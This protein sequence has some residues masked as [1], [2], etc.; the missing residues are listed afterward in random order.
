MGAFLRRPLAR[1]NS[2]D[3]LKLHVC[4]VSLNINDVT[5]RLVGL[6]GTGGIR[7]YQGLYVR[8]GGILER[9]GVYGDTG[10]GAAGTAA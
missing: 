3:V 10:S 1:T 7:A 6:G 8:Q 5:N 4:R 9:V 2:T